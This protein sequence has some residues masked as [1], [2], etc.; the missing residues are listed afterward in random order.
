MSKYVWVFTG[1]SGRFPVGVFESIDQAELV[2][3]KYELNGVLTKYPVNKST[4]DYCIQNELFTPNDKKLSPKY[5]ERFSSA[6]MDHIHY[7]AGQRKT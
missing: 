6:Y 5:V 1:S 3:L 4:L 2:I 7:E